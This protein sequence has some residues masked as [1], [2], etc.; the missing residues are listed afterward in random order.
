MR[1]NTYI[2]T[3][4]QISRR[5][6]VSLVKEGTVFLNGKKI[7]SYSQEVAPGDIIEITAKNF[8]IKETMEEK[9]ASSIL[10][11]FNKPV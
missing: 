4:H 1:L 5:K 11:L 6:F 7:D 9:I 3:R 8:Q 10:I 2:Q